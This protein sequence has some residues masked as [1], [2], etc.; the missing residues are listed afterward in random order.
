MPL[1][2]KIL[3]DLKKNKQIKEQGGALGIPIPWPRFAELVPLIERG[4]SIG[5]LGATGSGK[6]PLVRNL[7]VYTPYKYYKETGYKI[8]IFLYCLE[9]AVSKVYHHCICNYLYEQH[10][11]IISVKELNSKKGSLPDFVLE[12]LEE[13]T[14][15]FAEF[16]QIVEFVTDVYTPKDIYAVLEAHALRTGK[17]TVKTRINSDGIEIK[18]YHYE[19]DIHTIV[20]LDNM[21]NLDTD[22]KDDSE[23]ERKAMIRM[24]RDYARKRLVNFFNFTVVQVLQM[25]FQSERQQYTHSGLT[26]VSKLEPSLAG[27]GEAKTISRSQHLIIGLFDPSRYELLT[28]PIPSREDPENCYRIDILGN[29][30]RALKILKNN[31]G[32]A[33]KVRIPLLFSPLSETWEELPPPK[34]Q[35]LKDIYVKFSK[36]DRKEVGS[37][38]KSSIFAQ[39]EPAEDTPF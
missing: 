3:T 5:I 23:S 12:K 18:E 31:D 16:E 27:I 13:A 30:F 21:S 9:D 8:K 28:Y 26:I 6:S 29:R 24:S 39:D 17:S 1:F 15:Y 4:Q 7:Y 32:E 25:D 34:T 35:L 36:K 38:G 19:S 37:P 33:G 14:E 11:I 22:E 20:V 10:G 2:N